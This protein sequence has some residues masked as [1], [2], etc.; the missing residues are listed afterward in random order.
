MRPGISALV[1]TAVQTRTFN[2]AGCD[3]ALPLDRMLRRHTTAIIGCEKCQTGAR[4]SKQAQTRDEPWS[5]PSGQA[6]L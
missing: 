1:A 2:A 3:V 6:E 4:P 5:A